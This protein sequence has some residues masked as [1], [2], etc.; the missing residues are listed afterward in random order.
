MHSTI[1]WPSLSLNAKLLHLLFWFAC[2][3]FP[4]DFWVSSW[5][6]RWHQKKR[7]ELQSLPTRQH[8]VQSLFSI[9]LYPLNK[10]VPTRLYHS[11]RHF[12]KKQKVCRATQK[13]ILV[14]ISRWQNLFTKRIPSNK[15]QN[16]NM[17]TVGIMYLQIWTIEKPGCWKK[18]LD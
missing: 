16:A 7:V 8:T 6:L 2:K 13:L 18:G 4:P 11:Q 9:Q 14:A 3:V 17:W 10:M 1:R 15:T 12:Y 5:L